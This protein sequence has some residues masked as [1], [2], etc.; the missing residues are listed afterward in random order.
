MIHYVKPAMKSTVGGTAHTAP[1]P[2]YVPPPAQPPI[3]SQRLDPIIPVEEYTYER[4]DVDGPDQM[5]ASVSGGSLPGSRAASPSDEMAGAHSQQPTSPASDTLQWGLGDL[6]KCILAMRSGSGPQSASGCYHE[7]IR[8]L[9]HNKALSKRYSKD[10]ATNWTEADIAGL[11]TLVEHARL[12]CFTSDLAQGLADLQDK[13]QINQIQQ[14]VMQFC[15]EHNLTEG[16]STDLIKM[17]QHP[18]IDLIELQG[19]TFKTLQKHIRDNIPEQYAFRNVELH[20]GKLYGQPIPVTDANGQTITVPVRNMWVVLMLLYADPRYRGEMHLV[21]EPIFDGD[22]R[23]F[24][25][26]ASCEFRLH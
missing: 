14:M 22:E 10:Q 4:M 13:V 12:R 11:S 5:D 3:P 23:V 24:C 20:V 2:S 17:L 6:D 26:F 25:G 21:P 16:T 7:I 18:A 15:L 8:R 9:L 19:Q 1:D